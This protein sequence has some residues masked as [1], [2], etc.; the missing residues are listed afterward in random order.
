MLI[1]IFLLIFSQF[2]PCDA[3]QAWPMSSC[4]IRLS[5]SWTLSKRINISSKFFTIRLPYHSSFSVAVIMAICQWGPPNG[6]IECRWGRQKLPFSANIWLHRML[7]TVQLPS[8]THSAVRDRGK[9]MTLVAGKQQSL[10]M[11]GDDDQVLI[12]RSLNVTP[13]TTE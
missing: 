8:A 11:V 5:R 10:L 7:W 6:G 12:T 13:K 3:M 1:E 9:W 4:D 2:W